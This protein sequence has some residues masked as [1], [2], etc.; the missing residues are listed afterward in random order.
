[1]D[2][3]IKIN[4]L[5]KVLIDLGCDLTKVIDEH[6]NNTLIAPIL[7]RHEMAMATLC[8]IED[9]Y[10]EDCLTYGEVAELSLCVGELVIDM[11]ALE[12]MLGDEE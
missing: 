7:R 3:R 5:T 12:I 4:A 1:M 9:L 6:P 8:E 2:I 10:F 11:T